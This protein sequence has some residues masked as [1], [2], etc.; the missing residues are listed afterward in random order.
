MTLRHLRIFVEVY[1]FGSVT[2]AAET[3]RIAQPSV[4]RCIKEMEQY[5]GVQLFE[6]MYHRLS[7]TESAR[8]FY[9]QAV[10]LLD[11]F[12][13]ME[14]ELRGT[15]EH[16]PVRVGA[17]VTLG[18]TLLPRLVRRF[19]EQ[20]PE[21][22]I[23]VQVANGRAI[24]EA[25]CE[26]RLDV[27]ILENSVPMPEMHSEDLGSDRLCAVLAAD[28]PLADCGALT[29]EQLAQEPLLV[30]EK[31][32]TARTVLEYAFAE[33]RLALRPV[34]ESVS[35][36]AL[37][38]AAAQGLGIA[39]LPEQMAELSTRS[40][41]LCLRQIRGMELLRRRVLIWHSEKN[42]TEPMQ[43]FAALCRAEGRAAAD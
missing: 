22:E 6:R 12:S 20:F 7:P 19:G 8:R 27:A 43:R 18:S 40:G 25:L 36:G 33:R 15:P 38:Q 41:R 29:P 16:G 10:Y 21:V 17:T 23:R 26:N 2:R 31:G 9:P 34:W 30:R 39:I 5:Y 28:S 1:R 37:V 24:A 14:Q 32:S 35:T 11:T 42:L 4:T 13:H 3:L